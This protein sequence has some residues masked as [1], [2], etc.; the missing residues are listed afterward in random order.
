[1][2]SQQELEKV[3]GEIKVNNLTV[4]YRTTWNILLVFCFI[5]LLGSNQTFGK[6]QG[7]FMLP[8]AHHVGRI[9]HAT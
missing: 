7:L 9:E 5:E 6:N 3:R 2:R 8:R 1:M 4:L